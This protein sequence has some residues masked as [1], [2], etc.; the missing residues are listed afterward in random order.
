MAVRIQFRRG[1]AAEW[2][3]A[4]P[5]LA[6]GEL[7]YETDTAQMKIGNGSLTWSALPYSAV[8][9]A[10]VD[11]AIANV[12][13]L[14]PETLDTLN[15]LAAAM[16]DNPSFIS[17][18]EDDIDSA[19][20]YATG[21]TDNAIANL[22]A[23]APSALDTLNELASAL[24]SDA[25]F[26]TTVTTA[27]SERLQ[28][29]ADNVANYEANNPIIDENILAIE[30]DSG[31]V[32]IGDG[33]NAW[34]TLVYVNQAF[35]SGMIDEVS[36]DKVSEHN[37][38][39]T[40]VH[41]IA[42]TSL[43]VTSPVLENAISDALEDYTTTDDL[44]NSYV[45]NTTIE[46]YALLTDLE[47][48]AT[49]T[50]L[51]LKAPLANPTF[52]GT[53]SLPASIEI[54]NISIGNT[55]ATEISYLANVTSDVQSQIDAKAPL[56]SPSFTGTVS[57][58]T[59]T[60]IGNVSSTELEHLNGVTSGIQAQLDGKLDSSTA[61]TTY[62][63][64]SNASFNGTVALPIMTSIGNVSSDELGYLNGVTSAIQAQLDDKAPTADPTFTGTVSGVTKSHV[65][66]GDVDNTSDADKPI[67]TAT[68]TALDAKL[69]L[70]GG[71]LTGPL[72]LSG[73]PTSDLHAATKLYVDGLAAGINFHQPVV[74]ATAGNLAGTYDNGTAGVG[75]TLTKASNGAI[76]TIDGASV[77]VG[78]R[79]LL[80]AQTDAKENGVYVVTAVGSGSAPWVITRAA[81]A[82][83]NPSGELA[84]GDFV[85]VTGGSTNG[86]KGFILSTTGTVT[87]GTTEVNYAQFNASE[88]ITAGTNINKTGSTI[89]VV[90]D[91]TFANVVT[92]SS[93]IK[94]SDNT[95][96]TSAGVPSLTQ[97]IQKT[98]SYTLDALTLIDEVIEV[99][100]SSATTITI[101]TNAT[102]AWP[103]GASVDILQVGTG[104]VTIAA[105]GGVTLN[106]T[107]G[108]K[109]RT[110]WSSCTIMK[111]GTDS[112]IL[113]G[114]LTA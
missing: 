69:D 100:S 14:A 47:P 82:D 114:D 93:G 50:N 71:T 19:R 13:G 102:L 63:P 75:A 74:A 49:N 98:S 10:Y 28:F 106:F 15:E 23:S 111:R 48:Y 2:A 6:A 39:T 103:V 27:L 11:N 52:T 96:Q 70:A 65:G 31:N 20:A 16:G 94:F 109:L 59:T 57:L 99:D 7:G 78:S 80:R 110:R 24:G 5:T 38:D 9:E 51:D 61:A 36:A 108:N 83:N 101:P 62:A 3:S 17:D 112:W 68:Q 58:P 25:N 41:G 105:A 53:V 76:G 1:T 55:T 29:V 30:V 12:V 72:T 54:N 18:I 26:S 33:V 95:I 104:Q 107:P 77:S 113:Y 43:L 32:K 64:I 66:L 4:N 42:D 86:S 91:P 22:I 67:S 92:V 44:A 89:S 79:I 87:I 73:A 34:N 37:S 35:F 85:F 56:N 81:D 45:N 84:T 46:N 88:A 8:N 60:D 90:S 40:A 97:F 21:Y